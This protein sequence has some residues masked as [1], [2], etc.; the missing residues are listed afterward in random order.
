MRAR[1]TNR[2][3]SNI[4]PAAWA[5][6]W[7]GFISFYTSLTRNGNVLLPGTWR[8]KQDAWRSDVTFWESNIKI[9][10]QFAKDIAQRLQKPYPNK[11]LK[12]EPILAMGEF[13]QAVIA[14]DKRWPNTMWLE[15]THGSQMVQ[16]RIRIFESDVDDQSVTANTNWPRG[17]IIQTGW[18]ATNDQANMDIGVTENITQDIRGAILAAWAKKMHP[19]KQLITQRNPKWRAC[20]SCVYRTYNY[21]T[22]AATSSTRDFGNIRNKWICNLTGELIDYAEICMAT[23]L[24]NQR[25]RE[26]RYWDEWRW[27]TANRK[28]T[29]NRLI[30]QAPYAHSCD[31]H[32]GKNEVSIERVRWTGEN[33]MIMTCGSLPLDLQGNMVFTVE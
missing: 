31:K 20:Q 28:D 5:E 6:L 4:R 24:M 12:D 16:I 18:E 1:L 25:S 11:T 27:V 22:G 14:Q 10:R 26:R 15:L 13:P 32:T 7:G 9:N 33:Q 2:R 23:E 17:L 29:V 8:D 19:E 21:D 30:D 3:Q